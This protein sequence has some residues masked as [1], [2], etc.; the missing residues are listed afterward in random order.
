MLLYRIAP[1]SYLENY[2]GL[3][4]S[5]KDGARWNKAGEPVLYFALSSATA[6]LEMANYIP[7]PHLVPKSYRLGVYQLPD[8][9]K[10]DTLSDKKLPD[11]WAKFPYPL[12]TQTLGS[13]WLAKN[14]ALL[15]I[16]PSCAVP[17]GLEKIALMNPNH[18]SSKKI[19][20]IKA[21]PDL[22]NKRTFSG[23]NK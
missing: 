19:N 14:K 4:A 20:L 16:V 12:S 1:E 21:L 15:M 8:D 7:S 23:I 22:Y 11:D 10:Y 5:Y 3:G 13:Q 6:L 9:I 17:G 2:Q 18:P